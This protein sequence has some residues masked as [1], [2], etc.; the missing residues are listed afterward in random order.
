MNNSENPVVWEKCMSPHFWIRC[1]NGVCLGQRKGEERDSWCM[2]IYNS[3]QSFTAHKQQ[4]KRRRNIDL[5]KKNLSMKGL[6]LASNRLTPLLGWLHSFVNSAWTHLVR[7]VASHPLQPLT[8]LSLSA[9]ALGVWCPSLAGAAVWSCCAGELDC[10][11]W[12]CRCTSGSHLRPSPSCLLVP[13]LQPLPD[14]PAWEAV[15]SGFARVCW[16]HRPLSTDQRGRAWAHFHD[17]SHSWVRLSCTIL[18]P[19]LRSFEL[20]W[21]SY[22][23]KQACASH[24]WFSAGVFNEGGTLHATPAT[25]VAVVTQMAVSSHGLALTRFTTACS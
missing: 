23:C 19:A 17:T 20:F 4:S 22:C 12:S 10:C 6:L 7:F 11:W 9:M 15:G 2:K 25:C 1:R 24:I 8:P 16:E 14:I 18:S 21:G 3:L 13:R 5:K